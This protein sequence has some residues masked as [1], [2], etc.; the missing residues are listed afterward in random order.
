MR[1]YPSTWPWWQRLLLALAGGGVIA[2]LYGLQVYVGLVPLWAMTDNLK[3]AAPVGAAAT[4]VAFIWLRLHLPRPAGRSR[5]LYALRDL[6]LLVGCALL[7]S[8]ALVLT[9]GSMV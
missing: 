4:A 3:I 1:G 5:I 7:L 8:A 9:M 6:G 2:A